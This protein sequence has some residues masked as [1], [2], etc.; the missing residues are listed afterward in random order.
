[1]ASIHETAYP[2]IKSMPSTKD[3]IE[4]YTPSLEE[5]QWAEQN[6]RQDFSNFVL[7]VQLKVVQRLGY[8]LRIREIPEP[9]LRHV[10]NLLEFAHFS[11]V[12][13][14][15]DSSGS[16]Q[17]HLKLIRQ[18]LGITPVGDE[19]LAYV[20]QV[21][22]EA[23]ATK[24]EHA[25]IINIILEKLTQERFELPAFSTLV[26]EAQSAR[27]A[28][29]RQCFEVVTGSLNEAA[30]AAIDKILSTDATGQCS[31]WNALKQEPKQP[32][33]IH[34]RDFIRH[35][36]WLQQL[37]RPL[38]ERV[39]IPPA[40]I[41]R[42]VTEARA[43]N[44]TNMNELAPTKR[45]TLAALLIRAQ[46]SKALDDIA[47]IV[48]RIVQ[49]LHNDANDALRQ[50]QLDRASHLDALVAVLRDMVSAY[51]SPGSKE[52]RFEAIESVL[53]DESSSI[54]QQCEAHMAYANRNYLP[55][56][57]PL[58]R[59][60][61]AVLF[62]GL[63][64]LELC[65]ITSDQTTLEAL[66]FVFSHRASH[67]AWLAP[68]ADAALDLRWIPERWQ[69]MALRR[70]KRTGMSLLNRRYFEL[71]VFTQVAQEL[72]SGDLFIA[73]SEHYA[74]FR[75]QLI[76]WETYEDQAVEYSGLVGIE[77]DPKKLI[78]ELKVGLETVASATDQ[79]FPDNDQL[80]IENGE[81]IIRKRPKKSIPAGLEQIESALDE[82]LPQT[83]ILDVLIDTE[84]WLTLSRRFKPLSGHQTK[85]QDHQACFI[86]TLF[87]YG[88]N[89][90]PTQTAR[91]I[92]GFNRRQLSWLNLRHVTEEKLDEAI[93]KV[94]NAYNA[95]EL[96]KH[97]GSGSS[98][99]ADGTKWD[100]YEQ[101]LLSEYHIRYAGHGGLGYYHL[102]DTYIA[103]FSHFIP[104][105]VYEAV[106][107]LD[108]L[109]KNR[110][111]IQP[112]TLH[113]DTHSQ[114]ET[115]FGLAYLLGIK[116]MPRIR[117]I[118]QLKF[119][120]SHKG[121]LYEHI[122]ALFSDTLR[123]DLIEKYVPDLLRIALSIKAGQ[124]TPS[125][126]LRRLGTYSRKNKLYLA[127]R[128][129]GRV[130]RTEFLLQYI[131]EAE[132]RQMIQAATCKSEEFNGFIQWVLFGGDGVIAENLRHEQ[133]K[134]IKYN[135]LVANLLILH[136][137]ATLTKTLGELMRQGYA[138]NDEILAKLSPFRRG[139]INRFGAYVMNME[140]EV[141]PL[142][143]T[144]PRPS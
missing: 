14:G 135:H 79:S 49:K 32:T 35:L 142:E 20:R 95:F 70:D 116:L 97:W 31:V 93:V 78:A 133:R 50:H 89:L 5:R 107:I 110:S 3:L 105:G 38:P 114:S 51:Q 52:E 23:A 117:G 82:H 80:R 43:L 13:H 137:V 21:A 54:L 8:F 37:D 17:R 76:S 44:I 45:Y 122:D 124:I 118:K 87:C 65:S 125:T 18:H 25:D 119:Y 126:I 85:L 36:R 84:K 100:I 10:A 27:A 73:G 131:T 66:A 101:N 64:A 98:A 109:L 91:S 106:Y 102:S 108:G 24:E 42:F 11:E 2:R 115:V 57:L 68:P 67:R 96:P 92:Q 59:S 55:F 86:A 128:E 61:R 29:N 58:Y 53:A 138:I 71:C 56:M 143:F 4:V 6:T 16:R 72:K 121:I 104:C 28:I 47:E 69:K 144:I 48:I 9:I 60:K 40:K 1:M 7:L 99:S 112:D 46:T 139:H 74:D 81:P 88:C 129:L 62:N 41:K 123:W 12:L 19:T 90:G 94:V 140:R 103:L 34:V 120:R 63:E 141:E 30:R 15:Y 83:N 111:E 136:N 130:I 132:L 134:I 127:L 22:L 77:T 39:P 75:D 113:G 26:R 33:V